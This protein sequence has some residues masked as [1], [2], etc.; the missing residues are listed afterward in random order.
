[1]ENVENVYTVFDYL[2]EPVE[3]IANF[4]G[5]PYYY[6]VEFDDNGDCTDIYSLTPITQLALELELEKDR[7]FHRWRVKFDAGETTRETHP[8]LS[9][10]RSR[11]DNINKLLKGE[12]GKAEANFFRAQATFS[13]G[14][15]TNA[16]DDLANYRV[17]WRKLDN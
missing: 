9:N 6:Q 8:A 17:V 16:Q 10:D 1:M 14:E 3:G 2:D 15:D 13:R 7:I 11:F 4:Q 12:I 5:E